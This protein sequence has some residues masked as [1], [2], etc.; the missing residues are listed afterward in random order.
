MLAKSFSVLSADSQPR[1]KAR[2]QASVPSA[3]EE[4]GCAGISGG[5]LVLSLAVGLELTFPPCKAGQLP[6]GLLFKHCKGRYGVAVD[7]P[8]PLTS[9]R[10]EGNKRQR[11]SVGSTILEGTPGLGASG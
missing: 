10:E 5:G 11:L 3:D 8:W 2:R 6:P 7:R 1:H 9:M 4:A